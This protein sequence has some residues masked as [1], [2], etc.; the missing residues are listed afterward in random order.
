MELCA[1]FVGQKEMKELSIMGTKGSMPL[2]YQSMVAPNGLIA[3]FYGPVEGR[4][5]D[6]GMLAMSGLLSQLEQHSFSPNG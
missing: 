3:H 1:Q 2:K 5:H 6:S 4:R